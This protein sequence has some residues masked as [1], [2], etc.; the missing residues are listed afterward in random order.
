MPQGVQPASAMRGAG[1]QQVLRGSVCHRHGLAARPA[2]LASQRGSKQTQRSAQ[3]LDT[4]GCSVPA[5]E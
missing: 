2:A 3:P 4:E 1:A 5:M